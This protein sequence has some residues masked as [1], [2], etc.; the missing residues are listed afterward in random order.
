VLD[1]LVNSNYVTRV[2]KVIVE[3][4]KNFLACCG[5][6]RLISVPTGT[7]PNL[8]EYSH[9]LLPYFCSDSLSYY[10]SIRT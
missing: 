5:I 4:V 10:P 3:L 9:I 2:P 6:Q 8:H 1:L 7:R